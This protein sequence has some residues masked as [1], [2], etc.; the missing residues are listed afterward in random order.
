MADP[1]LIPDRYYGDGRCDWAKLGATRR[2]SGA[3]LK[4]TD[5]LSLPAS[6]HWFVDNW[7]SAKLGSG[8]RYGRDFF[9][10]AYHY[11]EFLDDGARQAS[12]F[13]SIVAKAGGW[14]NGDLWPIVD[15]ERGR[16]TSANHGAAPDTVRRCTI[17]FVTSIR[18]ELGQDA[19][20]VLYAGSALRD[21]HIT[22]AEVCDYLWTASYTQRL[23][24]V[25]G[26]LDSKVV[27]WQYTDGKHNH[28][29]HPSSAD[30]LGPTDLSVA[31]TSTLEAFRAALVQGA[32]FA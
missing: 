28:T 19:K 14:Q 17:D 7:N 12:H 3:I 8:D 11:L 2:F 27:L 25:T 13:L 24:P 1:I 26:W 6:E 16:E 10:G 21:L 23:K 4:A 30:G 29:D 20:I 22:L 32:S 31:R 18:R 5:G 9:R 15:V